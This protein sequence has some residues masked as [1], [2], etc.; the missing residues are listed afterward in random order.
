[1]LCTCIQDITLLDA[2]EH[3]RLQPLMDPLAQVTPGHDDPALQMK[4]PSLPSALDDATA[5]LTCHPPPKKNTTR[6][7]GHLYGRGLLKSLFCAQRNTLQR[8]GY[9]GEGEV[10]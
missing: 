3:H 9:N 1:M 6:M 10:R 7:N 2:P 4:D 8:C 5:P